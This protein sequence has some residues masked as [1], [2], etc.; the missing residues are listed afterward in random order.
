M[1]EYFKEKMISTATDH[2]VWKSEP[3]LRYV[4]TARLV[5]TGVSSGRFSRTNVIVAVTC[6]YF[7]YLIYIP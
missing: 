4:Y 5:Q 6:L 7:Q 1:Y 2:I 3:V